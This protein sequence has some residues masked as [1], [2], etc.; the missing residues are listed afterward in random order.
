MKQ[1]RKER[2]DITYSCSHL[3]TRLSQV[4]LTPSLMGTKKHW[5]T[6]YRMSKSPCILLKLVKSQT[7]VSSTSC[8]STSKRNNPSSGNGTGTVEVS[9]SSRLPSMFLKSSWSNHSV[10][11]RIKTS[12][13]SEEIG[14]KR[15]IVR[16][17]RYLHS[18]TSSLMIS[19]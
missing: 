2:K 16:L 1:K 12:S 11:E 8:S 6:L 14:E 5:S 10:L 19:H 3:Q 15:E 9:K 18:Q 13:R 17:F 4:L 7:V